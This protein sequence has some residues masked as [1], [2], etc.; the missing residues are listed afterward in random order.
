MGRIWKQ[1]EDIFEKVGVATEIE[2][3]KPKEKE[4]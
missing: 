3:V 1:K 4:L 2:V